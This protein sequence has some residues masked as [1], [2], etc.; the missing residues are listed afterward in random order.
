MGGSSRLQLIE[1][2]AQSHKSGDALASCIQAQV[3]LGIIRSFI[4][5][6]RLTI[7]A[8]QELA[9]RHGGVCLSDTYANS[10]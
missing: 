1:L 3:E 4:M 6:E 10:Q 5:P 8:M 9:K 2:G 7:Q